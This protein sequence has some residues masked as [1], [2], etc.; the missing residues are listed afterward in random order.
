M[1]A[2]EK[3]ISMVEMIKFSLDKDTTVCGIL[4]DLCRHFDR[5]SHILLLIT[6]FRAYGVSVSARDI[7]TSYLSDGIQRINIGT[8]KSEWTHTHKLSILSI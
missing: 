1:G 2:L 6:K 7:I 4:M 8:N 3:A 5:V